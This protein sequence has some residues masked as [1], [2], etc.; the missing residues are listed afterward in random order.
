M[1]TGFEVGGDTLVFLTD[2]TA[3]TQELYSTVKPVKLTTFVRWPPTCVDHISVEPAKSY[4][5]CIYDHLRNFS[6]FICWIPVYVSHVKWTRGTV[7]TCLYWPW[8]YFRPV[9]R[10]KSLLCLISLN[11]VFMLESYGCSPS[12]MYRVD[13]WKVLYETRLCDK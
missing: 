5:V 7:Y 13:W 4:I 10:R 11:C 3:L 2:V 12:S 6:T 9:K 1:Y 8:L